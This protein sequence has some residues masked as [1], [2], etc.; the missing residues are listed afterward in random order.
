MAS[1]TPWNPIKLWV[2][3]KAATVAGAL[4]TALAIAA[5]LDVILEGSTVIAV[6]AAL[7]SIA[8]GVIAAH[9]MASSRRAVAFLLMIVLALATLVNL[10]RSLRP[11]I[12]GTPGEDIP[13][14]VGSIGDP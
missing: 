14:I 7:L 3:H 2:H 5:S 10:S 8:W 1:E 11:K 12:Y 9:L 4:I 13:D 6:I